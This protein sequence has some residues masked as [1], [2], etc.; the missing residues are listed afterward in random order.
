MTCFARQH[1]LFVNEDVAS[2]AVCKDGQTPGKSGLVT[3]RF[4]LASTARQRRFQRRFARRPVQNGRQLAFV[5]GFI[6]VVSFP[7]GPD[8]VGAS[9]S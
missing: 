1:P 3:A 6:A 2:M 5:G 8:V 9:S 7:C 4:L